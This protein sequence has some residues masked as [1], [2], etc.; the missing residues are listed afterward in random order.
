MQIPPETIGEVVMA[1]LTLHNFLRSS[2]SKDVY[3][4]AGLSDSASE[5]GKLVPGPWRQDSALESFLSLQVPSIGH[6]ATT[7]AKRVR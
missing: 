5:D 1:A 4:P 2:I 7:E 3:F 6:N